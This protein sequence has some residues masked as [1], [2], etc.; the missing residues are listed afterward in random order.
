MKKLFVAVLLTIISLATAVDD[1]VARCG[2]IGRMRDR[3]QARREVSA[4]PAQTQVQ[5]CGPRGCVPQRR[6]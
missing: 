1:V 6:P 5:S 2:L 4:T 3:R